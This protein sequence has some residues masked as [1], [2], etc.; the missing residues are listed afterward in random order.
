M[1][2]IAPLLQQLDHISSLDP[3]LARRLVAQDLL[4]NFLRAQAQLGQWYT[5]AF[6]PRRPRYWISQD[7]NAQIPFPEPFCFQDSLTSLL[8]TY[9]WA[10][11]VL[12]LPCLGTLVHHIF[13]PVVDA[14]PHVFPDLPPHL[15]VDPDSYSTFKIREMAVTVCRGLDNALAGTT[16]P[17]MLVFPVKV[18][19]T[20]YSGIVNQAGD[21]TLELMWLGSF[22]ERMALRGQDI[23]G[24]T[25]TRD[26]VDLAEW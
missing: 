26:W 2:Q 24:A 19:E 5:A 12:F 3:T 15:T 9:Y 22:R 25:M 1:A 23:A 4:G 16:Q 17:D 11:Q 7:G 18:L 20:F 13:S 6:D 10:V 14:Y 8:F 21:G